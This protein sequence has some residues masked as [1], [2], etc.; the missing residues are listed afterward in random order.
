MRGMMM[1]DL[2]LT[3]EDIDQVIAL[4]R[5]IRTARGEGLSEDAE[6][7]IR[8]AAM[9]SVGSIDGFCRLLEL[10]QDQISGVD[11]WIAA[12]RV[13]KHTRRIANEAYVSWRRDRAGTWKRFERPATTDKWGFRDGR[14]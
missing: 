13:I 5:I 7:C 2:Q 11:K 10:F 9:M 4:T 8:Q 1:S 3:N 6:A 14:W 12:R